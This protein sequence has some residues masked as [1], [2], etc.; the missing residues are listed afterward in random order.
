MVAQ[1][2]HEDTVATLVNRVAQEAAESSEDVVAAARAR[3]V[4]LREEHRPEDG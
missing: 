1:D 4:A 3:L 2:E